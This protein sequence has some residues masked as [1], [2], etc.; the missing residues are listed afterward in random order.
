MPFL[1][2]KKQFW[3]GPV[4]HIPSTDIIPTHICPSESVFLSAPPCGWC[5]YL[6]GD[7]LVSIW[8]T[9][10]GLVW[11][12]TTV[13]WVHPARL[14]TLPPPP[15]PAAMRHRT[16]SHRTACSAS[17][18]CDRL[19]HRPTGLYRPHTTRRLT[20][21]AYRPTSV[22]VIPQCSVEQDRGKRTE[23]HIGPRTK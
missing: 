22:S 6:C 20:L 8:C 3:C 16:S 1:S 9:C 13:D 7:G 21:T 14:T 15:P 2:Q 5:W 12:V 18:A 23:K 11:R 4:G 19:I 10:C 17:P